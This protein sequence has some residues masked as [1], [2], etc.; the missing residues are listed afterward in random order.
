MSF[1]RANK[2]PSNVIV[3]KYL[4][5]NVF[6]SVIYCRTGQ[7]ILYIPA[8][9]FQGLPWRLRSQ[10]DLSK[11]AGLNVDILSDKVDNSIHAMI[12]YNCVAD[13]RENFRSTANRRRLTEP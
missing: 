3:Y 5:S 1:L 12:D 11:C 4:L 2:L 9:S 8:T 6:P 7:Q 10:V 13:C